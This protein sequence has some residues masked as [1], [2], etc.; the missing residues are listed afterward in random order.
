MRF[1]SE[2]SSIDY[3]LL[4]LRLGFGGLML[5]GH[6]LGKFQLL[7]SGNHQ[8]FPSIFGLGG[9]VSLSLAVF[10]E[11]LC[12]IF[13][14]LGFRTRFSALCLLITMLVAAF[15]VHFSDSFFPQFLNNVGPYDRVIL[16]FKEHAFLYALGFFAIF[17]AGGGKIAFDFLIEKK[18][19]YFVS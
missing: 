1:G 2:K 3:A 16:P 7:V 18:R 13:V 8:H 6:G 17:F 9:L 10:S 12:A 14:A 4:S 15:Y 19:N 5:I 11:F